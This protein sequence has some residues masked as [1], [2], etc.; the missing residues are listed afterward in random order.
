[1]IRAALAVMLLAGALVTAAGAQSQAA[2]TREQALADIR[3]SDVEARRQAAAWLGE[4]G[5]MADAPVLIAALRDADDVVRALAEH[6]VW[7]VWS[8]SGNPQVDALF[9]IGVEQMQRGAGAAA[10]ETFGQIISRKPDFA[11][12]WNKR[13][14]VY[15]LMGEYAK[16][17][18]DCDEVIKR[19]PSHFGALA[20][21]GQ[22][23]LRLNQPE[24]ALD[25]FQRALTV[26]PNLAGVE[27]T[28][29][30]LKQEL[31]EKR[32]GTI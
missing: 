24:R 6:S 13:A 25:Y 29:E 16:S 15:F 4:L 3:K 10:I 9:Q 19:N 22:I 8:R 5:T 2:L 30:A 17:L 28:I 20:G 11:E 12:G 1:M 7:Q 26:N 31:I 21:Y 14:T 32:K 18:K 23:Y 27:A